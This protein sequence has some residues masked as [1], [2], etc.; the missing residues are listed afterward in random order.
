[1]ATLQNIRDKAGVLVAIVIGA[2]LLAFIL[3]DFLG[4]GNFNSQPAVGEI[5]G[6]EIT[7][8][9]YLALVEQY[10]DNAKRNNQG[11]ALDTRTINMI[12]D[13]AWETLV[14]QYTMDGQYEMLGL[15]VT[16]LELEDMIKGKFIAPEIQQVPIFQNP[17]TKQF[18]KSRVIQFLKNIDQDPSG[19]ARASWLAFEKSLVQNKI[20]SKYNTLIEKSYFPNKIEVENGVSG[21]NTIADIK[22]IQKKY[23]DIKDEEVKVEESDLK[24]YYEEHKALYQ[25][26]ASRKITYVTFDVVYSKEDAEETY[27]WM[28]KNAPDFKETKDPIRFINL[29]SDQVFD[30]TYF[31]KEELKDAQAQNLFDAEIGAV[32]PIYKD[33]D[34]YKIARLVNVKML[35]DSAKASHILLRPSEKMAADK[36]LALSDSL[37]TLLKNGAKFADLAKEFSQDGSSSKGGD[38]GWFQKGQM[39]APFQKAC[40]EGK[41]GDITVAESQFGLH[42]IKIEKQGE[43][44]RKVQVGYLSSKIEPSSKTDAIAYNKAS[45]FSGQNSTKEAFDAAVDSLKIIPRVASNIK[46]TDR[47]IAGLENARELIRWVYKAELNQV[48]EE[49]FKIGDKYVIPML[50]EIKE[51]GQAPF[52]LVKEQ[53]ER[54]VIKDKKYDLIAKDFDSNKS[55]NIEQMAQKLNLEVKTAQNISF[56]SYSV[57]GVGVELNLIADAVSAK[58]NTLVAPIKGTSGVFAMVTTSK[59][60][61]QKA[62]PK[63]EADK[64]RNEFVNRVKYQ[65]YPAIK[66]KATIVDNRLDFN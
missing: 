1:M 30:E 60:E 29:N 51:E 3:G 36:I 49:V 56:N 19:E 5:K 52:E 25:Q 17:E 22:Y 38:L 28:S 16:P 42:I 13:Q 43:K 23:S 4:K 47:S 6:N 15:N 26:K 39:V 50:T 14:R 40:F 44:S 65:V 10:Q 32:S 45:R 7:Y 9:Q 66:E 63:V 35:P 59:K 8:Q 46:T 24:A 11:K 12:Y 18:D 55:D 57:P 31:T 64:I 21:S 62:T 2:S 20:S 41:E 33:K 54:E 34:S 53:V 27:K 58:E 37:Q 61:E 48:S